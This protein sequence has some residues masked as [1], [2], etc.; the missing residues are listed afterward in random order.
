MKTY[1]FSVEH[2]SKN[3]LVINRKVRVY[4]VINNKPSFIGSKEF[5]SQNTYGNKTEAYL[6]ISRSE[7]HKMSKCGYQL[8]SKSI[9]LFELN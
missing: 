8:E 5:N 3:L 7:G 9:Q 4:R 2:T 1:I 6:I